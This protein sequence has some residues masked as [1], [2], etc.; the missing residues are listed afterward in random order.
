MNKSKLAGVIDS[1]VEVELSF[2]GLQL[3]DLDVE[4]ADR[5]GLEF[6]ILRFVSLED[7][8]ISI[9]RVAAGIDAATSGST[10]GWLAEGHTNN[11]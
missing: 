3:G 2:C 9:C 7:P 1:D 10:P 6:L 11:H 8:P 5:I 4:E